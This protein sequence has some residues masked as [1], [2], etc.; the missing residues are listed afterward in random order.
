[1]DKAIYYIAHGDQY[2]REA[3]VSAYSA[4]SHMGDIRTVM[5]TVNRQA[6]LNTGAFSDVIVIETPQNKRWFLDFTRFM[7]DSVKVLRRLGYSK[8]IYVDTDTY[9]CSSVH[10]VFEILDKFD[11]AIAHAPGRQTVPTV[12]GVPMAFTEPNTGV[13]AMKLNNTVVELWQTALDFYESN[14]ETYHNNDQGAVRDA[15]WS[16]VNVIDYYVLAP[17]YN[18]RFN[19][20]C[21][22]SKPVKILHGHTD[23][24]PEMA[25]RVNNS[26][27]MRAWPKGGLNDF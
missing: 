17:E 18:F 13:T 21:F 20:P 15:L 1:M 9:F 16:M 8:A 27:D 26:N 11:I 2:I 7:A 22:A 5:F 24:F 10:D 4:L 6:A 12:L 19:F 23:N 14:Q 3:S 25:R